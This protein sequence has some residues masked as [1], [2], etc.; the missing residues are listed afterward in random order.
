MADVIAAEL[1]ELDNGW[2]GN[3]AAQ[4]SSTIATAEIVPPTGSTTEFLQ[5]YEIGQ[6]MGMDW[7]TKR[8]MYL[9]DEN[10]RLVDLLD[11]YKI[12]H[13]NTRK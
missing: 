8:I 1:A 13:L 11:T 3:K 6:D 12:P 10:N 5:E 4:N 2:P 7:Y 9:I